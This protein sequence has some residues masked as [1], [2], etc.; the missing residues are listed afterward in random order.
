M[1]VFKYDVKVYTYLYVTKFLLNYF[2]NIYQ[3][4]EI[5]FFCK[6]KWS[7]YLLLCVEIEEYLY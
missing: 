4:V 7:N 3:K 6:E 5:I 1:L 2:Q